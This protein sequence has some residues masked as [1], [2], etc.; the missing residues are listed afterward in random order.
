M[1]ELVGKERYFLHFYVSEVPN[2]EKAGRRKEQR[3][4]NTSPHVS[5]SKE[6]RFWTSA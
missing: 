3:T 4:C 2:V 5:T 6:S 1:W